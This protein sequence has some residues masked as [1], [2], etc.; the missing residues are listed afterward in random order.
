MTNIEAIRFIIGDKNSED[1]SDDEIQYFLDMN[2][3]VNYAVMELCKILINRLRKELLES[4][5]TATEKTD[6]A[7]LRDR[8]KLLQEIL[9]EYKEKWE[10]ENNNTTGRYIATTKPTIAGGDI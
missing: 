4:D 3:N 2:N 8:L 1:F 7:P 9:D 5:T 10:A 6:L